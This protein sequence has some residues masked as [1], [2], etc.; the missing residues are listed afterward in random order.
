[1]GFCCYLCRESFAQNA[2]IPNR[3]GGDGH[4]ERGVSATKCGHLFHSDCLKNAFQSQGGSNKETK[5][6]N[7]KLKLENEDYSKRH[8]M[9]CIQ[10][11]QIQT[12]SNNI[13]RENHDLSQA[14]EQTRRFHS[15]QLTESDNLRREVGKLKNIIVTLTEKLTSTHFMQENGSIGGGQNFMR[16]DF[17]DQQ[18]TGLGMD[19]I[20]PLTMNVNCNGA[21][22]KT[23]NPP[24]FLFPRA[25]LSDNGTEGQVSPPGCSTM[26]SNSPAGEA[27]SMVV[28]GDLHRTSNNYYGLDEP[29][30]YQLELDN[31]FKDMSESLL[32][33]T[34]SLSATSTSNNESNQVINGRNFLDSNLK[35]AD[36]FSSRKGLPKEEIGG[37]QESLQQHN[38]GINSG[39]AC[40]FSPPHDDNADSDD[41]DSGKWFETKSRRRAHSKGE[42]IKS[43]MQSDK[44]LYGLFS[45][46]TCKAR[47]GSSQ[48]FLNTAQV[49]RYCKTEVQPYSQG[50]ILSRK[51]LEFSK[52]D[53][54]ATTPGVSKKEQ[55]HNK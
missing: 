40:K 1:M 30:M 11:R 20:I 53:S 43:D 28:G 6:L 24:G 50:P 44:K 42:R 34:A 8:E 26:N 4:G 9:L 2:Y 33:L 54:V 48:S 41:D 45:C 29:L 49:C 38:D 16:N 36:A 13:R 52:H 47:W 39:H 15:M 31:N 55:G 37:K 3:G 32:R 14:L 35:S 18:F 17:S 10:M 21:P 19:S 7:Q 51:Q 12:E 22:M 5:K 27:V 25:A 46:P 23:G